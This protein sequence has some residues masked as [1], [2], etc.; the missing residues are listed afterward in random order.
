MDMFVRSLAAFTEALGVES[1][2][3]VWELATFPWPDDTTRDAF[4]KD[5]TGFDM[6]RNY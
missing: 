2:P 3:V 1:A 4:I 6:S 5:L